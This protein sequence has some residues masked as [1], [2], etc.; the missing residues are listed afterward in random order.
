MEVLYSGLSEGFPSRSCESASKQDGVRKNR[1]YADLG[2]KIKYQG[3]FL[4]ERYFAE[5]VIGTA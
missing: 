3:C 4:V 1:P 5:K 2:S